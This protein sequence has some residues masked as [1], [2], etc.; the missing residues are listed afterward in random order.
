MASSSA[1]DSHTSFAPGQLLINGRPD[2]RL[3]GT[4]T[5]TMTSI[6]SR[7]ERPYLWID[8]ECI[9]Q[10]DPLILKSIFT[11]TR[12]AVA[13]RGLLIRVVSRKDLDC[14]S[15]CL[16]V[17]RL[18]TK[19]PWFQ[20]TWTFHEKYCVARL[21]FLIPCRYDV[22]ISNKGLA[23]KVDKDI[24]FDSWGLKFG[25]ESVISI[26]L[27]HRDPK[28]VRKFTDILTNYFTSVKLNPQ[29]FNT[30]ICDSNNLLDTIFQPMEECDNTTVANLLSTFAN[31]CDFRWR[32]PL[33]FLRD[34]N[35][36]L[37][38]CM[39]ILIQKNLSIEIESKAHQLHSAL[40]IMD[41]KI[42]D[43]LR[44]IGFFVEQRL[45]LDEYVGDRWVLD[46]TLCFS[47]RTARPRLPTNSRSPHQCKR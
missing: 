30:R 17:L 33:T 5:S 1:E 47:R 32:L 16:D 20:R 13:C 8:Q 45:F 31:I 24:V 40:P 35:V 3:S 4:K 2:F 7:W 41:Y 44:H 38:T 46:S 10:S 25:M 15:A 22:K 12:A 18:I 23:Y 29:D 28:A 11:F 9:D 6:S 19:G 36:G 42:K 26:S 14:L 21:V 39:L 34:S 37:S 27:K 43:V